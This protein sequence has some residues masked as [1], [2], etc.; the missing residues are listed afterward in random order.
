MS[1]DVRLRYEW[2]KFRSRIHRWRVAAA[3][4]GIGS[5]VGKAIG[6]SRASRHGAHPEGGARTR[7]PMEGSVL[8]VDSGVPQTNRDS[9][10]LR[11]F[12]LMKLMAGDGYDVHFL[13]E[14][15]GDG[16]HAAALRGAGVQVH[17]V[18]STQSI[19]SWFAENCV[20]CAAVVVAR[21]NLASYWIA[22]ARHLSPRALI[23][24]DT[25]DLHHVREQREAELAGNHALARVSSATR[26]REVSAILQS[27]VTWVVSPTEKALLGKLVPAARVLILPNLHEA[28]PVTPGPEDRHGLL[29]IG[30]GRHPPNIDAARW[31]VTE[32][33]P[34]VRGRLPECTLELVG[35]DLESQVGSGHS[36]AGVRFH[37]HVPDLEGLVSRCKVGLAPL[38][39]GAG[40]K[41][42]VN[43]YMAHGLPTVATK[44]AAEGMHLEHGTDVLIADGAEAFADAVVALHED[45]HMWR[46]LAAAGKQNVLRHFSFEGARVPVTDTF[47]PAPASSRAI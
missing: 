35:E 27:D 40:V 36:G 41:G 44:C 5:A 20:D 30:G 11:A 12:N 21:H 29:F 38:R 7:M 34:M 9:G 6:A 22:M 2:G 33:F 18:P 47:G 16:T 3:S 31:L 24:F 10:S 4:N 15:G 8:F 1:I 28:E 42:K 23:V 39:F 19:P 43:H 45:Q 17:R 25:V 37:G 26:A 14:D 13:A 46:G 32:I